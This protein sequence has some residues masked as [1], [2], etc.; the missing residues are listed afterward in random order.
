MS[1]RKTL[2]K[3]N[4]LT[5]RNVSNVKEEL[6]EE[7]EF[8]NVIGDESATPLK[9]AYGSTLYGYTQP[10][11]PDIQLQ[12]HCTLIEGGYVTIVP[13]KQNPEYAVISF[14]IPETDVQQYANKAMAEYYPTVVKD[15]KTIKYSNNF[16]RTFYN[17][18]K[19]F[20]TVKCYNF[21]PK[22][23]LA[24]GGGGSGGTQFGP[25]VGTGGSGGGGGLVGLATNPPAMT[26]TMQIIPGVGGYAATSS[27]ETSTSGQPTIINLINKEN[28]KGLP[29]RFN[30]GGY[31]AGKQSPQVYPNDKVPYNNCLCPVPEVYLWGAA[32][33]NGGS[34]GGGG[35]SPNTNTDYKNT[36]GPPG[37]N[38]DFADGNYWPAVYPRDKP[39]H[40]YPSDMNIFEY[41]FSPGGGIEYPGETYC[42]FR[43]DGN[44]CSNSTDRAGG[45]GGGGAGSFSYPGDSDRYGDK[46]ALVNKYS[47]RP[48]KNNYNGVAVRDY[49]IGGF[50]VAGVGGYG[51]QGYIFKPNSIEYARGGTGGNGLDPYDKDIANNKSPAGYV[52]IPASGNN[53]GRW[54]WVGRDFPE[55]N[56]GS[57][58]FGGNCSKLAGGDEGPGVIGSNGANGSVVIVMKYENLEIVKTQGDACSC[59]STEPGYTCSGSVVE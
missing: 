22:S 26:G 38:W 47:K 13:S 16:N 9:T 4:N 5:R 51:G 35:V 2:A 40:A 42:M 6:K 3:V 20:M 37:N 14:Q 34:G 59:N 46:T 58:G 28:P 45:G 21:S 33:A 25:W 55:T 24:V 52:Y 41:F 8:L 48:Q 43:P 44:E 32:G 19:C 29:W 57:G 31:G 10:S 23:I 36:N 15:G 53:Y 56:S 54:E 39:S 7:E 27:G 49:G 30:G 1:V 17:S 18:Y 50:S 11:N 12:V